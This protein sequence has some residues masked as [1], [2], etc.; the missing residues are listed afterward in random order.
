MITRI[1]D[2]SIFVGL[3]YAEALSKIQEHGYEPVLVR[4]NS[5]PQVI[6]RDYDPLR[7]RLTCEKNIVTAAVIG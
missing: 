4:S 7:V 6:L 3:S 1:E 5:V 2:P